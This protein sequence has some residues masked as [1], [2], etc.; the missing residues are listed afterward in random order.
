M[1]ILIT[2]AH[3]YKPQQKSI[4]DSQRSDPKPR[5]TALSQSLEALHQLFSKSQSMIDINKRLAI[6]A[7]HP[8]TNELDIVI[9]TTK[10]CHLL[11]QLPVPE[12][13]Y[14]H[15]PTQVEPMLLGFECQAVL[16]DSLGQY[17]TK[18]LSMIGEEID[19]AM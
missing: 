5:L 1:K 10:D 7:N 16:R 13:F 17:G 8:L 4:Y 18:F 9:C 15:Y 6:P 2:I 11:D 3:F 12:H 14:Q 19:L